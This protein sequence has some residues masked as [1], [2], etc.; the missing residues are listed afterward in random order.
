MK[1][2]I[3]VFVVGLYLTTYTTAAMVMGSAAL[4][5]GGTALLLERLPWIAGFSLFLSLASV[6]PVAMV[7]A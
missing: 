2:G 3:P 7:Y 6:L 1:G 4:E 5:A